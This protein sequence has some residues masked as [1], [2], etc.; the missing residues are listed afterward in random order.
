MVQA[1]DVKSCQAGSQ[2]FKPP[3]VTLFFKRL[4]GIHGE[5][6]QLACFG[7][8]VRRHSCHHRGVSIGIEFEKF[9]MRPDIGAFMGY[10][11]GNIADQLD[12]F[13]V[14]IGS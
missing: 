11:Q 7:E 12:S 4:P 9:G 6:P 5:S 3:T 2:S 8:I 1:I 13:G 14:A 10:E